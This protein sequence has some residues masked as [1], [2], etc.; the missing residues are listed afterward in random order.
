MSENEFAEVGGFFFK[1]TEGALVRKSWVE[2]SEERMW[3]P[4]LRIHLRQ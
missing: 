4:S 3:K 1:V 2:G